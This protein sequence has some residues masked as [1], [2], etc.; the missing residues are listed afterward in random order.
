MDDFALIR[1]AAEILKEYE[2]GQIEAENGFN[3]FDVTGI[4]RKEVTTCAFLAAVLKP[5]GT[6]GLGI[7]P[8]KLFCQHVLGIDTLSDLELK[9]ARLETE[10]PIDADRRID[11][12]IRFGHHFIPI[13]AKIYAADQGSQ[14]FDYYQYSLKYDSAAVLYYLTLDGHEPSI[15]SRRG[16]NKDQEYRCISFEKEIL[17]W[18]S[19][20]LRED[21][22]RKSEIH[23]VL[24]QYKSAVEHI[25][26]Q[27]EKGVQEK[28]KQLINSKDAFHAA[29]AIERSLPAIKA[30][31]MCKFFTALRDC[32]RSSELDYPLVYEGF[33]EQAHKYYSNNI[34]TWPSL[35]YLLPSLPDLPDRSFVLRIEIQDNLYYGVCNWDDSIKAPP[36]GIT[37]PVRQIVLRASGSREHKK[38]TDAFYWWEYLNSAS[39]SIDFRHCNAA[40]EDLYDDEL[41]LHQSIVERI[42]AEIKSFFVTWPNKL[43]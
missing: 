38:W 42:A 2:S 10:V 18:I 43:D 33:Q 14:C 5:D 23:V 1:S 13:E 26:N 11:I 6:H 25:T 36:H 12:L 20:L 35:N 15:D 41:H 9:K 29:N 22:V 17:R 3:I 37:D 19:A 28:M 16:L 40:Y 21:V 32:L 27:Q 39:G 24:R 30:E 34:N 4:S 8:L 7:L 31:M